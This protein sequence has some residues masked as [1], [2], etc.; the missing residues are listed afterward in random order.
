METGRQ[1]WIWWILLAAA[2]V[3]LVHLD[4]RPIGH[5]SWRQADTASIARNFH[6]QGYQL[7]FPRIDWAQP[8]FVEMEFPLYPWVVALAYGAFGEHTALARLLSAA[9]SVATVFILFLLVRRFVGPEEGLWAAFVWAILPYGIYFGRAIMP[10]SWMLAF[11]VLGVYLFARWTERRTSLLFFASAFAVALACLVKLPSLY[12]GLPL[13]WLAWRAFGRRLLGRWELWLFGLLVATPVAAWYWHAHH[14]GTT[15]GATFG[16]LSGPTGKLGG[17]RTLLDLDFYNRV[18]IVHFANRVLTLVG[19]GLFLIGLALP[20]KES[21][22]R[23][24]DW[25][26]LGASIML[27]AGSAGSYAHDYYALPLMIP[28]VA[29]A[30]K[31]L[32]RIR[33]RSTGLAAIA[34]IGLVLVCGWRWTAYLRLEDERNPASSEVVQNLRVARILAEH[35][36]PTETTISCNLSNP[37][38]LYLSDRKGWGTRCDTM[39][40]AAIA[41]LERRGARYLVARRADLESAGGRRLLDHLLSTR[42][43]LHDDGEVLLVDLTPLAGAARDWPQLLSDDFEDGRLP[44]GWR[45]EA[46]AWNEAGGKLVGRT[47]RKRLAAEVDA[48]FEGCGLCAIQATLEMSTRSRRGRAPSVT[49]KGWQR[50][51]SFTSVTLDLRRDEVR[52]LQKD[53]GVAVARTTRDWRFDESQTFALELRFD[54]FDFEVLVDDRLVLQLPSRSDAV[55]FGRFGVEGRNVRVA[56]DELAIRAPR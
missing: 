19:F 39:S 2:L 47:K 5:H 55:P 21:R 16:I 35:T 29:L 9:A 49:F 17:W 31:A 10:E 24:F 43:K 6:E 25:W 27:L 53:G 23:L 3:R 42:T 7:F 1:R 37:I 56:I 15:F 8:G 11:S 30:A 13:G 54:N 41:V 36:A 20:R 4:A 18:F 32:A 26:L 48:S 50:G 28:G 33:A 40:K 12:L 51:E 45:L 52:Y 38:W 34:V 46:G 22:E 14:L 44:P